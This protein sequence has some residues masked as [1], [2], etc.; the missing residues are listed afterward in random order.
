MPTSAWCD[1]GPSWPGWE[2]GA[3]SGPLGRSTYAA[4]GGA[5]M[6]CAGLAG[7]LSGKR[8]P[9]RPAQAPAGQACPGRQTPLLWGHRVWF[10]L[11]KASAARG[12]WT[13][14]KCRGLWPSPALGKDSSVLS[15]CSLWHGR[16][17]LTPLPPPCGPCC[18]PE[19]WSGWGGPWGPLLPGQVRSPTKADHKVL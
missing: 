17:P 19:R 3:G 13:P 8:S 6:L 7:T 4:S 14:G 1:K 12:N 16:G 2:R 15:T 11:R 9:A 10:P 18:S 5:P